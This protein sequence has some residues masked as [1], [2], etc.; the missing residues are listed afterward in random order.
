MALS[1]Q[2]L[3]LELPV[4]A[5]RAMLAWLNHDLHG[6]NGFQLTATAARESIA[7]LRRSGYAIAVARLGRMTAGYALWR[8]GPQSVY[9]RHFVIRPELRRQGMGRAFAYLLLDH[10]P[11]SKDVRLDVRTR[12]ARAFWLTVGF[13]P[14][15]GGLR[16]A[17]NEE[18]AK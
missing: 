8:V 1:V 11:R 15:L 3:R 16:Y 4:S 2:D 12:A 7:A 14:A 6:E 5:D 17:R 13:R 9:V 10:L 18:S